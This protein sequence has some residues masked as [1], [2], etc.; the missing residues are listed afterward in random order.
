[1]LSSPSVATASTVLGIGAA[2]IL[3]LGGLKMMKLESF[4]LAVAAA[5]VA[6]IPCLSPCCCIG[7]PFGIWGL[8]VLL[9][10]DV[11]SCFT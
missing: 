8:V 4:G 7:L 5:V 3:I 9:K 11:K 10:D 2:V 1:M 6:M